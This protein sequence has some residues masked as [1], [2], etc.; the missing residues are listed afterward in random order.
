MRAGEV[1]LDVRKRGGVRERLR[2]GNG[3]ET[4]VWI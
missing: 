2:G 1:A 4:A 3:V